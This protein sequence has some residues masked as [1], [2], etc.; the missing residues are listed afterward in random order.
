MD[1]IQIR[2]GNFYAELYLERLG[3]MPRSNFRKLLRLMQGAQWE[4]QTALD[5]LGA[6][7]KGQLKATKTAWEKAG[8]NYADGWK[9]VPDKRSRRKDVMDT[10]QENHRLKTALNRAKGAYDTVVALQTI[11]DKELCK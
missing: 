4:N 10:L 8:Q 9:L 2:S 3:E 1:T 5:S 7:L 6:Y 11:Y